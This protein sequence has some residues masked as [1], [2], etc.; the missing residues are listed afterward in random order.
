M[1]YRKKIRI[2]ERR[3]R[4]EMGLCT[5]EGD[6]RSFTIDIHPGHK[7]EKSRLNTTV[8]EAI[9]AGEWSLS[10]L[11]TRAIAWAVTHVLWREGWRRIH[12]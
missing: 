12:K 6:G 10:E 5:N 8:H 2:R 3:M 11:R 9:H 7:R 1:G 4:R